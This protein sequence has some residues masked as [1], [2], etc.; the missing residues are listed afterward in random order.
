MLCCAMLEQFLE[1]DNIVSAS[2]TGEVF[3]YKFDQRHQVWHVVVSAFRF[4]ELIA[5]C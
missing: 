2:S 4:M 1:H 5:T 3:V